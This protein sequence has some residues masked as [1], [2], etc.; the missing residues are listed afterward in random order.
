MRSPGVAAVL[1]LTL[2][3][4]GVAQQP[5]FSQ[6]VN[7]TAIELNAQILDAEGKTPTDL[8]A[9]DF[10]VIED[11]IEQPVVALEY[12]GSTAPAVE[13]SFTPA[14]QRI[15]PAPN[16]WNI[17]IYIDLELSNVRTMRD[18]IR[19]LTPN[20]ERFTS[21]GAVEVVVA[22][23]TPRR[24]LA[25]TRD[26]DAVRAALAQAERIPAHNRV[27]K[28]RR[29]FNERRNNPMTTMEDP[30]IGNSDVRG[31]IE[32]EQTI[33]QVHLENLARWMGTYSRLTP[34]ALFLV[35]DGFDL[36]P[37]DYYSDMFDGTGPNNSAG[38]A[39]SPG[40]IRSA[41][42]NAFVPPPARGGTS[43]AASLGSD[44]AQKMAR[45]HEGVAR[46][47][48]AGGWTITPMTGGMASEFTDDAATKDG[49]R[50]TRFMIGG[51]GVGRAGVMVSGAPRDPLQQFAEA[52][53]GTVITEPGKFSAAIEALG[54]R[55]RLTYQVSRPVDG[56]VR[57]VEVRSKRPGL[58]VRATKWSSSSTPELTASARAMGLLDE[59][60]DRGELPVV[61]KIDVA[62]GGDVRDGNLLARVTLT[63][64]DNLR[65][66]LT[67]TTIR[68]SVAVEQER[69]RPVVT[70]ILLRNYDLAKRNEVLFKSPIQIPK[71][72]RQIAVTMEE[73]STGSW[74]GA[75]IDFNKAPRG[76]TMFAS[77]GWTESTAVEEVLDA[78]EW[79]SWE[80]AV[81]QAQASKR[82]IFTYAPH[83]K[84][85][86]CANYERDVLGDPSFR[87]QLGDFIPVRIDAAQA[88]TI[89]TNK[90]FAVLDPWGKPRFGWTD[91]DAP[92]LVTRMLQA[93]DLGKHMIR[94]GEMLAAGQAAEGHF[95]LGFM[96]LQGSVIEDARREYEEARLAAKEAGDAALAQRAEIQLALALA[97]LG[98]TKDAQRSLEKVTKAPVN[99]SNEAEAWLIT[100]HMRK[101]AGDANGALEAYNRAATKAP[102]G[103]PLE[104]TAQTLA[105]M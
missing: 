72:T 7:V 63:P 36:N 88:R 32:E 14:K 42:T 8:K 105:R 20:A 79:T 67:N 30:T 93:R 62:A 22:D 26:T 50:T 101:A 77:A 64:I 24:I 17:V 86:R 71:K 35:S 54:E 65:P 27:T 12:L 13:A 68:V 59:P 47:A 51:G 75:V 5:N 46:A 23:P 3:S 69:Q 81:A 55:V 99:P 98:K 11:G 25:S 102:K 60:S 37:A 2:T 97:R 84:C 9:S 78:L 38:V 96:Y 10:V 16:R 49:R 56:I 33:V 15:R 19:A 85:E 92:G 43:N 73:L 57:R 89:G 95:A 52:T 66:Q 61:A 48:A 94:A 4:G 87:V 39:S 1:L 21:L 40:G 18:A 91:V 28:I 34:N 74:G 90:T 82:L 83:V 41:S 6:Q 31:P 70:H 45:L 104:R 29:E 80:T 53:G 100:G 58:T 103:S 44:V 76:Q